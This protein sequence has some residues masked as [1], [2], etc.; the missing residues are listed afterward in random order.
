MLQIYNPPSGY[1][2]TLVGGP[3]TWKVYPEGEA[4]YPNAR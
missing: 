3:S 4:K 2:L 1:T